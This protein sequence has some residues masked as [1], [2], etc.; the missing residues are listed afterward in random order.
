[1]R[2]DWC[3][4]IYDRM[5][6][7][8]PSRVFDGETAVVS[9]RPPFSM[10]ECLHYGRYSALKFDL[11]A[12]NAASLVVFDEFF[13]RQLDSLGQ[14]ETPASVPLPLRCGSPV[15]ACSFLVCSVP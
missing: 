8:S 12:V 13:R 1:M 7:W 10:R 5:G 2:C 11:L 4:V 9:G 6:V 14:L 15:A 3:L